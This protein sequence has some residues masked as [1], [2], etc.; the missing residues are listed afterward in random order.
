MA[1][2]T[3][4]EEL[5]NDWQLYRENVAV[6]AKH[7]PEGFSFDKKDYPTGGYIV[8]DGESYQAFSD[9][10]FSARYVP[11]SPTKSDTN[12]NPAPRYP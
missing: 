4:P 10:Q 1:K 6:R 8:F 9:D 7:V 2:F 12:I 3:P 5:G 11:V